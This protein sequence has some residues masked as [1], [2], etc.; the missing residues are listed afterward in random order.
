MCVSVC[1]SVQATTFDPVDLGTLFSVKDTSLSG[2]SLITKIIGSSSRSHDV[3]VLVPLHVCIPIKFKL[4]S[5]PN[6]EES[7]LFSLF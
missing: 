4:I 7:P 6:D 5:G 3:T 2:S 1:L